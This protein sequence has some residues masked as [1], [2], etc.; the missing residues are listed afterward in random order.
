LL[1]I[2]LEVAIEIP[3]RRVGIEIAAIM[4]FHTLA[5]VEDPLCLVSGVLFPPLREAR[6]DIRQ[7]VRFR[8][9]PEHKP[10]ETG[11]AEEAHPFITIVGRACRGRHVGRGHGDPQGAAGERHMRTQAQSHCSG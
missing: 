1:G 11:V 7:L 5:E 4:E 9:I 6:A 3:D 8:K 10:F 2:F